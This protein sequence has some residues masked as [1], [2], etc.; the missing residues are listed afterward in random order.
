MNQFNERKQKWIINQ[1]L[2]SLFK[3]EEIER[4]KSFNIRIEFEKF[5]IKYVSSV[6]ETF[7]RKFYLK[8]NLN[9]RDRKTS[10]RRKDVR[11][12]ITSRKEALKETTTNQ[13][14]F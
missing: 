5:K 7:K 14:I 9:T 12:S 8:A 3:D 4:K 6:F 2:K 1:R 13:I 11:I 10:K